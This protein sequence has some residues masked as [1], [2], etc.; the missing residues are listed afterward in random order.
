MF[1]LFSLYIVLSHIGY[2]LKAIRFIVSLFLVVL[3]KN[4]KIQFFIGIEKQ[5]HMFNM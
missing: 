5:N 2:Y 3:T 1:S 4:R